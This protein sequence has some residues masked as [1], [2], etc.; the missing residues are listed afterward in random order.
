[1]RSAPELRVTTDEGGI[2]ALPAPVRALF[3]AALFDSAAWYRTCRAA[4]LP[5]GARAIFVT[6]WDQNQPVAL[7]PMAVQRRRCAAL[8][9]P[10]T[11]LWR[12]LLAPH[13]DV[14]AIGRAFGR[15]CRAWPS[16]HLDALDLSESYWAPLL[17]G[18]REA[19]LAALPH[20]HFGNWRCDTAGMGWRAYL[21]AR[22]GPTREA[23]RR[24]GKRLMADGATFRVIDDEANLPDGIAA[25]EA[26]YAASWKQP[27]PFPRFNVELM[28]ECAAAGW[29]RLGLLEQAGQVLAAQIW[30]VQGPLAT[31]LKLAH[32]ESRKAASPGTVLTGLMIERLLDHEHVTILDFG[33]GDD[34]YKRAWTGTRL[35]RQGLVLANTRSPAG[36]FAVLQRR[37]RNIVRS[38]TDRYQAG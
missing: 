15:W 7:L 29:L 26:V 31:V 25:Y 5:I 36:L 18:C 37:L 8:T 38:R 14:Q 13:A 20:D 30:V 2:N 28:R 17:A 34:E 16:V 19:G 3:G 22:P 23:V 32:D 10:Y 6:V 11:C 4:G 24:R 1:M 9:T 35:P 21:S 12:P 33:R 27:E